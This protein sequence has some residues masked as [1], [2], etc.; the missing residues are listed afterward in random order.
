MKSSKCQ[1]QNCHCSY[2]L[3]WR[4]SCNAIN[5]GTSCVYFST[6]LVMIILRW[7]LTALQLVRQEKIIFLPCALCH[8]LFTHFLTRESWLLIHDLGSTIRKHWRAMKSCKILMTSDV[9]LLLL[10]CGPHILKFLGPYGEILPNHIINVLSNLSS[11][12]WNKV[13]FEIA[14]L[15]PIGDVRL[16]LVCV[17]DRQGSTKAVTQ[18]LGSWCLACTIQNMIWLSFHNVGTEMPSACTY[19]CWTARIPQRNPVCIKHDLQE[20]TAWHF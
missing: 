20:A 13:T 11:V 17:P 5:I 8:N 16:F 3:A 12:V 19:A 6:F 1:W 2:A 15:L 18:C 14:N 10:W 4:R 9:L 7:V